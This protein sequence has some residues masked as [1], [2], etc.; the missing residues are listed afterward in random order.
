MKKFIRTIFVFAL[1]FFVVDKVF[2]VL[3][4][5]APSLEKDQRLEQLITGDINKDLIVL[6]SSRGARNI[7]ASQIEEKLKVSAFNL[8]YPGSDIEFHE[9][10]LRQLIKNNDTPETI[11]LALDSPDELLPIESIKFRLDRLYPLAG[12]NEINKELINR[13]ENSIFSHIFIVDRLNLSNFN[14]SKKQFNEIDAMENCGSMPISFQKENFDKIYKTEI[15]NYDAS[16]ELKHK[17]EAFLNFQKICQANDIDL[18]LIF[19]PNYKIHDQ[20]FEQ[21]IKQISLPETSF[22]VYD[23]TLNI[24]KNHSLFFDE[25]HLIEQ[26]AQLFTDEIILKLESDSKN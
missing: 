9:F 17:L 8:S 13:E 20:Q 2:Y 6:G 22:I 14:L 23:T 19:S 16:N 3:L 5:I 18:Y 4:A 11:L 21:R 26:G 7:I 10:L 12:Y 25:S 1:I 15:P 24:Y